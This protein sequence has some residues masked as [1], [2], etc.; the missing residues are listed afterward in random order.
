VARAAVSPGGEIGA[1]LCVLLG[2]ARGDTAVD[3]ERLGLANEPNVEPVEQ[4]LDLLG[5]VPGHDRHAIDPRSAQ[6]VQQGDDH[7]PTVDR[8]HGLC[9]ALG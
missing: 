5:E 9:V 1:G 4:C 8:Q 2:V 6:L 3:A 7:G